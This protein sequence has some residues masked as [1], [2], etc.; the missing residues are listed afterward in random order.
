MAPNS[1]MSA[2]RSSPVH[3]V[4][5]NT[6]SRMAGFPFGRLLPDRPCIFGHLNSL[7]IDGE[8][9]SANSL[10]LG[11]K[12]PPPFG[13]SAGPAMN[14]HMLGWH[15]VVTGWHRLPGRKTLV[16]VEASKPS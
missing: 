14:Q 5:R 12:A 10:I 3:S 8:T 2:S 11:T 4:S 7:E 6:S 1:Q 9:V 16:A 15:P 13:G